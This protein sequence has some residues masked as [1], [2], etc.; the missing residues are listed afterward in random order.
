METIY[1]LVV[2]KDYDVTVLTIKMAVNR[3]PAPGEKIEID[4]NDPRTEFVGGQWGEEMAKGKFLLTVYE[5]RPADTV[6]SKYPTIVCL[7]QVP[8]EDP[9]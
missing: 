6:N 3:I 8:D 2:V 7:L 4:F 1:V 9:L 5:S